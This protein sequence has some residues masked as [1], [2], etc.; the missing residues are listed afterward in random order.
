M[1]T[2]NKELAFMPPREKAMAVFTKDGA[3]D[4]YLAHVRAE[5][6]AFVPDLTTKK[7][8]DAIASMA[9]KVS[10]SKSALETLGK[11]LADEAKE[12]PKK[13]DANRKNMRDTLDSWRDEVRKPLDDWQAE[14]DAIE[15]KRIAD[16]D[17]AERIRLAEIAAK[18]L[19]EQVDRDHELAV[20]M[21]AE[22]LRQKEEAAKQAIIDAEI[23]A[24]A[25]K[26]REE[27]IARDAA[28]NAR[29]EADRA[30]AAEQQRIKDE[31]AKKA[32]E[33]QAA[34][35]RA[36]RE[37][38][39]AE[40]RE[41]AQKQAAEIAAKQ[42]AEKAERDRLQ[43]IAD[44]EHRIAC[45]RAEAEAIATKQAA[46]KANQKR[47]NNEALDDLIELGLTKDLATSVVVAL[48]KNTIRNCTINY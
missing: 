24:N 2:E 20:F 8:R 10:Q 17:E 9:Y 28:E 18:E 23:A 43:A 1:T 27:Q 32:A 45:E 35:D 42:A 31:A 46:N 3:L 14:Q 38:A 16:E 36:Q 25:Q 21:Y 19:Q 30:A 4:P 34:I 11:A 48:A 5:I 26:E 7:G 41:I 15:A 39:E 37:K 22:H 29:I 6:D 33:A 40:A 13:I 44:T 47:K 12:I